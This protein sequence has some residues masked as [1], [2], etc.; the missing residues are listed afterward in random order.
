MQLQRP[1]EDA[2]ETAMNERVTL[3]SHL[4]R[5]AAQT[6]HGPAVGEVILAIAA[7]A[8]TERCFAT[9]SS[10]RSCRMV[11]SRKKCPAMTNLI[12]KTFPYQKI[13]KFH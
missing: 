1:E 9:A 10:A 11:S 8:V 7:A 12:R 3:R 4:D 13:T 5:S 2:G 6:P